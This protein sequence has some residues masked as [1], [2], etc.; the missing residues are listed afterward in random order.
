MI[1]HMLH[2][3]KA[4]MGKCVIKVPLLDGYN[5]LYIDFIVELLHPSPLQAQIIPFS[6]L[7]LTVKLLSTQSM[8]KGISPL[9][10]PNHLQ[11]LSFLN[12]YTLLLIL[13]SKWYNVSRCLL[14]ASIFFLSI[15]ISTILIGGKN[16]KRTLKAYFHFL[17]RWNVSKGWLVL[18]EGEMRLRSLVLK[19][20]PYNVSS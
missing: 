11:T 1:L 3:L 7:P 4:L 12:Y 6:T 19:A 8:K 10:S 5:T 9:S 18:K 20:F 17:I 16:R 2:M 15:D 14:I 13:L